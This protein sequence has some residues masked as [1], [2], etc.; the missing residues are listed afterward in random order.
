[1]T[2]ITKTGGFTIGFRRGWSDWQKEPVGLINWAQT[3]GFGAIDPTDDGDTWSRKAVD[4]GLRIGSVDF[5]HWSALLSPE[6]AKRRA[7]V[8]TAADYIKHCT[9]AG[10]VNFFILMLPEKPE[11]PRADNFSYM[12]DSLSLL[13]PVLEQFG[14]ALAIEGWPG[15]GAL[16]CTPETY[17]AT[18]KAVPSPAIGI[19]YDPSHLIRMGIDPIRFLREFVGRVR[20]VHG[21]DTAIDPEALYEYGSEQAATFS[22]P[23]S[24]GGHH[25][26]YTIPGN[27][28]MR[29]RDAFNILADQGYRGCVSIELED[30]DFNGSTAG[31]QQGLLAA[32]R[33]LSAC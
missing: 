21:K 7:A 30:A 25:W 24:F 28:Q 26:R 17:R 6:Q 2:F 5:P 23:R 33:Y 3:N 13:A 22:Q 19:N 27:G 4:S 20:H 15:P 16:C 12:V 31:E 18:F 11:L 8:A 32:A 9:A 1:M 29:W 10:A 14:G